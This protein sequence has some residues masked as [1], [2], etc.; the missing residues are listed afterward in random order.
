MLDVLPLS[1]DVAVSA[2]VNDIV[3]RVKGG[4]GGARGMGGAGRANVEAGGT[5]AGTGD[6]YAEWYGETG[7]SLGASAGMCAGVGASA[8]VGDSRTD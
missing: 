7:S 1:V 4:T 5:G 6:R 3:S 8:G 2:W